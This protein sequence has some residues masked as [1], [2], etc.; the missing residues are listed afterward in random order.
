MRLARKNYG[1]YASEMY[2]EG[3]HHADDMYIDEFTGYKYAKGQ[4]TWLIEKGERLPETCPKK[5]SISVSRS[6]KMGE[7][8]EIGAVLVGCLDDKAPQRYQDDCKISV[9][10]STSVPPSK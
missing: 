2:R 6:F 8:R 10:I 4:M 3:F 1:T 9:Q 7:S 5:V